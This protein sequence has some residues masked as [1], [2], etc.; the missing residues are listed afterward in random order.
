MF[1]FTKVVVAGL[2]TLSAVQALPQPAQPSSSPTP[3]P[4]PAP[5]T[6]APADLYI[7]PTAVQFFQKLLTSGGSLLTGDALKKVVVFNFNGGT[8]DKG[9]KGGVVKSAVCP[10]T[11]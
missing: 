6:P 8:P 11:L 9:A 4:A 10:I 5:A 7:A 3:T 2:A 1:T